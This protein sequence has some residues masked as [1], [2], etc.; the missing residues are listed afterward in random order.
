[1]SRNYSA[2]TVTVSAPLL[3]AGARALGANPNRVVLVVSVPTAHWVGVGNRNYVSND[4][5]F[6]AFEG[7]DF[8][9]M[10]YRDFGPLITAEIFIIGLGTSVQITEVARVPIG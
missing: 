4:D 9:V 3:N 2:R 7:V 1:M 8:R 10:A 5:L 6:A